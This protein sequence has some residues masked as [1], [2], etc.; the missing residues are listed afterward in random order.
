MTQAKP[1]VSIVRI[2][3]QRTY[4]AV[5]EAVRLLGGVTPIVPPGARVVVKPNF[6]QAPANCGVTNLWTL[7]AVVRLAADA[8]A[9]E[10]AI[11]EAPGD[12]YA[13]L[14]FRIYGVCHLVERYGARLV[15][16]NAE[17]G[18]RKPVPADLGREYVMVPRAVAEADVVI[19]VP[20]F[21]LWGA[22]PLSL[23]LKNLVGLYG[24]AHYGYNHN[25]HEW[26][27][28]HPERVLDG[29]VG[30]ELGAHMPT[31]AAAIT[32]MN[33]AVRPA[34]TVV[35][36]IEG[37]NGRGRN[38]RL[39]LVIAGLQPMATDVVG[40]ALGG[41]DAEADPSFQFYAKW[42]LG[43]CRL[44]DVE[45]RGVPVEEARFQLRRLDE[46][47]VDLPVRQ[48]LRLI[49]AGELGHMVRVLGMYGLLDP[50]AAPK[51]R[52]QLV[53][54]LAGAISRPGYFRA[55]LGKLT[56]M[57]LDFL[58]LLVEMGGTSG[59]YYAVKDEFSRRQGDGYVF[60]PCQRAVMRLGLAYVFA[61]QWL[62]Y[63]VLAEGVASALS[64][65]D[66]GGR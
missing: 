58:R 42:G 49:S 62:P 57:Q 63:Y 9:G 22:S 65:F 1:V 24:G 60:W 50:D 36:A 6:T 34:L 37:G 52:A 48:C 64:Q 3:E 38:V 13:P 59:S 46:N 33:L 31:T 53:D 18:V 56:P 28:D 20:T 40:L 27:P 14:A 66:G 7:D 45:V 8:G 2:E 44:A 35:D 11:A 10:I 17:P 61:G 16:L 39:D 23:G 51:E 4:A 5:S 29:E 43:S 26:L 25:S 12:V 32:A 19:S 30:A 54:F 55:A 21:K 41:V 15:D 47:V